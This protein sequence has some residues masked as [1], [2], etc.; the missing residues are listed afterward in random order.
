[1]PTNTHLPD[2]FHW[3]TAPKL[4]L[5]EAAA[6]GMAIAGPV[7][8]AGLMGHLP[9]GMAAAVGSMTIGGMRAG[10]SAR[11][12]ADELRA[13]LLPALLAVVAACLAAGHGL[14][15]DGVVIALAAAAATVGGYSRALVAGST[16]FILYLIITVSVIN[17]AASNKVGL[18]VLLVAGMIWATVVNVAL[19][20]AARG[21]R[22]GDLAD[23]DD[24]APTTTSS[25]KFARWRRSLTH[26]AGWQYTIR[27]TL[28]L[29][30]AVCFQSLFPGHHLYWVSVT[31]AVLVQRRGE[32]WSV[33][34][35]QR[36]LGA[37]F[38][39]C[40][41]SVLIGIGPTDWVLMICIGL[42]AAARPL[43]RARSY[44]AYAAIMIP[45][46]MLLMDAGHPLGIVVLID[47]VVATL[48]GA[49]LVVSANWIVGTILA[50]T[51]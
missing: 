4:D 28:C 30:M 6:S 41:A 51:S 17:N 27:L 22:A 11:W 2:V 46:I 3:S 43:L 29:M 20:A 47:R 8:I 5:M 21:M 26:V 42:L 10:A 40:L 25:Q 23:D 45:L 48:I 38:G 7:L 9:L 14:L 31:V 33:K 34:T 13:A 18:L 1:M 16:R 37:V 24:A 32:T 50:K 36:S 12:Q 49:G 39:V 44:L 15:T 19:G 35:T